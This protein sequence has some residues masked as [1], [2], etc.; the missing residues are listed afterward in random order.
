MLIVQGLRGDS[1]PFYV[2]PITRGVAN[3]LAEMWLLPNERKHLEF[4][5]SLLATAPDGGPF[6]CGSELTA[7]DV[8]M[9]FPLL[10][11]PDRFDADDYTGSYWN[12]G[13]EGGVRMEFKRVFE[14]LDLLKERKAWKTSEERYSSAMAEQL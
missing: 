13:Q 14:Y 11:G 12:K 5:D 7:A 9:S 6:L 4:I 10:A 3:K 1:V 8:M 2:R